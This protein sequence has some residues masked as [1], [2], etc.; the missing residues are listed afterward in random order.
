VRTQNRIAKVL[1]PVLF[2]FFQIIPV[3]ASP[4]S[5]QLGLPSSPSGQ[6]VLLDRAKFTVLYDN[7]LNNPTWV[8]EYLTREDVESEAVSRD[9]FSFSDD[10]D[11]DGEAQLLRQGRS[12]KSGNLT[13]HRLHR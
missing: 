1:L 2:L 7:E 5:M 10:P 11:I 12:A 9:K 13:H 6:K 4:G 3:F 8:A